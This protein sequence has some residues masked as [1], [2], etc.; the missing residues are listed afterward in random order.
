[1]GTPQ[2]S[3]LPGPIRPKLD[4][5]QRGGM[6]H[7]VRKMDCSGHEGCYNVIHRGGYQLAA[8]RA[9]VHRN[10]VHRSPGNMGIP[11][12]MDERLAPRQYPNPPLIQ[13]SCEFLFDRSS[14]WDSEI[15][16]RM[17]EKLGVDFPQLHE[18]QALRF[19][20]QSTSG[21]EDVSL[22]EARQWEFTREDESAAVQVGQNWLTIVHHKPYPGWEQFLPLV[23]GIL[24]IYLDI[25]RPK[26][27]D[28][29]ELQYINQIE[30]RGPDVDLEDYLNVYPHVG[31]GLPDHYNSFL[32]GLRFPYEGGRD[33]LQL[34]MTEIA[35]S[36]QDT[37]SI[38]LTLSYLMRLPP[39][40]ET[41][42]VIRLLDTAHVHVEDLFEGCVKNPLRQRFMGKEG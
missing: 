30:L 18:S 11:H 33:I 6:R 25:A 38:L 40:A 29:V 3:G 26:G 22:V 28:R 31:T 35:P 17:Q 10:P 20:D 1:M 42:S 36:D 32:I 4:D 8:G 12:S 5:S 7:A 13:T 39:D 9:R 34:I 15:V 24:G 37:V 14:P 21:G 19:P 23:Q 2:S 41:N 16:D 27:F